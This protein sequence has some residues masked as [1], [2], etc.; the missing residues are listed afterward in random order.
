VKSLLRKAWFWP[1]VTSPLAVFGVAALSG[2][3][4]PGV[5]SGLGLLGCWLLSFPFGRAEARSID[6]P[7]PQRQLAVAGWGALAVAVALGGLWWGM[8]LDPAR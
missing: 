3:R 6:D 2:G 4:A 7:S 8:S 1:A 5:V